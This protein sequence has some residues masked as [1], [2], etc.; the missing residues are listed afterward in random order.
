[1]GQSFDIDILFPMFAIFWKK[2]YNLLLG[3]GSKLCVVVIYSV[4]PLVGMRPNSLA[5]V[6]W[7]WNISMKCDFTL[8][9]DVVLYSLSRFMLRI[10]SFLH[11]L[12]VVT[13]YIG[14][15]ITPYCNGQGRGR[16]FF[17]HQ[18]PA[19]TWKTWFG[20]YSLRLHYSTPLQIGICPAARFSGNLMRV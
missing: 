5:C 3:S 10:I 1:M 20:F 6:K 11:F 16:K 19:W 9:F 14:T 2:N 17:C 13:Q 4:G 18:L 15:M 7:K 8:N 12:I